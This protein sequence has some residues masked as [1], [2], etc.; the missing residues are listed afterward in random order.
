MSPYLIKTMIATALVA[1]GTVA[2]ASQ[3]GLMGRAV[4]KGDPEK[5]RRLH[6]N[7][8]GAFIVL[9][10]PLAFLGAKFWV[11]AGDSLSV[12][13]GFHVVLALAFVVLLLLKL[14]I[15]RVYRGFLRLAPTL[16]MMVFALTLLVFVLS[17]VF[18]GL[19][20]VF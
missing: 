10:L 13:A 15:V 20:I 1:A 11:T 16:G 19:T 2:F 12:R 18:A 5:L 7:A 4:R 6:R 9:I 3:M 14:L 17:A 8:G